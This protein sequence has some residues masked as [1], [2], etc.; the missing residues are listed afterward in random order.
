MEKTDGDRGIIND[1]QERAEETRSRAL[2]LGMERSRRKAEKFRDRI[3][4]GN[5][6]AGSEQ[7]WD[8]STSHI[9]RY[10]SG[11]SKQC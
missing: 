11:K 3:S 7:L 4:L 6:W 5:G 9:D 10:W 8:A 1:N 2:V